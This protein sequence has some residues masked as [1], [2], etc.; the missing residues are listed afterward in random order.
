MLR[1]KFQQT[2]FTSIMVFRLYTDNMYM[3]NAFI[4]TIHSLCQNI[5]IECVHNVVKEGHLEMTYT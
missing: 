4:V 3:I 2:S 5:L 1:I